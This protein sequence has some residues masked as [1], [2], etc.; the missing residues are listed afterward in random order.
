MHPGK[1]IIAIGLF[2]VVAGL[3]LLA[4]G[5]LSWLE[6][7]PGDIRIERDNFSLYFPLGT[8]I[9]LSLVLSFLFWLFRR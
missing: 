9:L 4:G 2:L 5:K 1:T 6:K 8:S 7:L 3:F